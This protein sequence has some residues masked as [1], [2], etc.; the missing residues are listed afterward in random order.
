MTDTIR[1][2]RASAMPL[3]FACGGSQESPSE[4]LVVETANP[5]AE[6]GT[7]VHEVLAAV[8]L[9]GDTDLPDLKPYADSHGV[10]NMDEF[11]VLCYFGLQAQSEV[12]DFFPDPMVEMA[13]EMSIPVDGAVQDDPVLSGHMDLYQPGS[14][15]SHVADYKSGR[16]EGDHYNQ[17]AAYAALALEDGNPKCG[18]KAAVIQ[19]REQ[20]IRYYTFTRAKIRDW[21]DSLVQNVVKWDGSF[22]VGGH[23]RFC[24]RAGS[25]EARTAMVRQ[26]INEIG[27]AGLQFDPASSRSELAPYMVGLFERVKVVESLV[28]SFIDRIKEEITMN[29]P[30]PSGDGRTLQIKLEHRDKIDPE[31][32][33]AVLQSYIQDEDLAKCVSISKTKMLKAASEGAPRGSKGAIKQEVMDR[34]TE[35]GAITQTEVR[36]LTLT[37]D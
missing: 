15:W 32:A 10:T 22:C 29:G 6:L 34:L 31:A 13:L 9:A 24:R 18:V 25:C 1:R 26:T 36:K 37:K 12:A 21:I 30:L 2:L 27:D 23:C 11:R 19:L 16:L 28:K 20:S 35:A 4:G 5:M 7:A 33:W 17:M 14:D 8:T 3:A